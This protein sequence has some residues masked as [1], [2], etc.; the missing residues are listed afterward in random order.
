MRGHIHQSTNMLA[1]QVTWNSWEEIENGKT[2]SSWTLVWCKRLVKYITY[3]TLVCSILGN[4]RIDKFTVRE[5][6]KTCPIW[7]V[8]IHLIYKYRIKIFCTKKTT[9]C[10]LLRQLDCKTQLLKKNTLLGTIK[11]RLWHHLSDWV[12]QIGLSEPNSVGMTQKG[13]VLMVLYLHDTTQSPHR[14][15]ALVNDIPL[16][17]RPVNQFIEP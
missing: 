15:R 12:R 10:I 13:N 6:W 7:K 8:G 2:D 5:T 3:C 17:Y 11:G 9:A 1:S 4:L 16:L 14:C